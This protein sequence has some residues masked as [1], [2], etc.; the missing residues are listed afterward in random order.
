MYQDQRF[1]LSTIN[2]GGLSMAKE[3]IDLHIILIGIGV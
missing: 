1:A 2:S 3:L